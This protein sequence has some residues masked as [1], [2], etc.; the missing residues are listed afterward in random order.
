MLHNPG[1]SALPRPR[2]PRCVAILALFSSFSSRPPSISFSQ[3]PHFSVRL[4][5]F[6]L[7]L[8][9]ALHTFHTFFSFFFL[10][11]FFLTLSCLLWHHC[12][13]SLSPLFGALLYES[14]FS[15]SLYPLL[16]VRLEVDF[17]MLPV[18]VQ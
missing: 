11:L 9:P 14:L 16:Q 4:L 5:S 15:F 10:L 12:P 13:F 7:P 18:P 2:A 6:C 3:V 17:L 8:C 1:Y